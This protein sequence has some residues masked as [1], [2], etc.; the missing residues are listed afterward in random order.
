M[1]GMVMIIGILVFGAVL[2]GSVML[3]NLGVLSY[4][5]R[6]REFATLK[7]LGFPDRQ[8][9]TVMI[10]QNVWV[11]AAGIL[12]GLRPDMECF[13]I[14]SP[15]FRNLWISRSLSDGLHGCLAP[16]EP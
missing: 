10:Q 14:C 15:P 1:E 13:V 16:Q 11:C 3:Y 9:R 2:L 6:Y 5:E 4:M 12:L 7:V 8:I